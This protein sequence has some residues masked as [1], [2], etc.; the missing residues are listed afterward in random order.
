M[1][2]SFLMDRMPSKECFE[3]LT[4]LFVLENESGPLETICEVVCV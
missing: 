1:L 2:H 3:L 4:L